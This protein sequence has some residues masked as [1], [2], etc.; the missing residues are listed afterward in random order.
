MIDLSQDPKRRNVLQDM[1][2]LGKERRA[3]LQDMFASDNLKLNLGCG[4]KRFHKADFLNIDCS[5]TCDPDFVFN[6]EKDFWPFEADSV[7]EIL[8]DNLLEHLE[9]LVFV[10]NEAWRVTKSN[11][12][13]WFRVPAVDRFEMVEDKDHRATGSKQSMK[14]IM[15]GAFRDPTHR[16]FFCQ[17]TMDYWQHDHPTHRDYGRPAYGFLPW[18][19]TT[20]VF[21]NPRNGLFFYDVRQVPIK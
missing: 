13:F 20:E 11:G 14:V 17:E 19:V 9:D 21:H 2:A 6:V 8:A 1:I 7:I 16:T 4:A 15:W 3:V 5:R 18:H 12:S 10:M